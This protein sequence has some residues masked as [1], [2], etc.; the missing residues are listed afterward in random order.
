MNANVSGYIK[1]L[2]GP[3]WRWWW[4]VITGLLSIAAFFGTPDSGLELSKYAI[5][6]V[7]FIFL[8]ILFL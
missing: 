3:F 6:M 4:A 7:I 5:S 2:L 1:W 8:V